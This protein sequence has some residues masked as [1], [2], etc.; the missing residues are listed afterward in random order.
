MRK[1][2]AISIGQIKG[3]DFC[4]H[5]VFVDL[6]ENTLYFGEISKTEKHGFGIISKYKT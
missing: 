5:G 4:G 2:N 6:L 3:G 1:S